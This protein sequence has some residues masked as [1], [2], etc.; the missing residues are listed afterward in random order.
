VK[1]LLARNSAPSGM[2][3]D[4]D[5]PPGVGVGDGEGAAEESLSP[6]ATADKRSADRTVRR[7]DNIRSSG[8]KRVTH[9]PPN[10]S[11]PANIPNDLL[12]SQRT[13]VSSFLLETQTERR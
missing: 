1:A 6:H 13:Y 7:T 9:T 5:A 12:L 4:D 2:T 3:T 8:V 11:L 10:L